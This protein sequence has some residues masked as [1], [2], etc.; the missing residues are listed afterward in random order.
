[1]VFNEVKLAKKIELLET[2]HRDLTLATH[3]VQRCH[4]ALLG[5]KDVVTKVADPNA[6]ANTIG[7]T[8]EVKSKPKD[9]ETGEEITPT[10]RNMIYDKRMAEA[11]TLLGQTI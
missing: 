10:R 4:D 9:E 8:I 5:I 7:R 11:T 3:K 1:M 6:P 2:R